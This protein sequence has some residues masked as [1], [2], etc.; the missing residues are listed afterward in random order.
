MESACVVVNIYIYLYVTYVIHLRN[1]KHFPIAFERTMLDGCANRGVTVN[2]AH[3]NIKGSL[4]RH[5]NMKPE[6]F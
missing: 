4:Q 3:F 5:A 2:N 6:F 1:L